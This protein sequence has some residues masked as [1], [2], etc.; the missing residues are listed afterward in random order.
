MG[1][2]VSFSRGYRGSEKLKG[3]VE[4]M[5]SMHLINRNNSYYYYYYCPRG[6]FIKEKAQSLEYTISFC[7]LFLRATKIIRYR[8]KS[9]DKP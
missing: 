4:H 5:S 8:M 2:V 1:T 7:S 9:K 6:L 3:Y